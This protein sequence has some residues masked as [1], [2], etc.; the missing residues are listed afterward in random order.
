MNIEVID[1]I[2]REE[3]KANGYVIRQSKTTESIYIDLIRDDYIWTIRISGHKSSKC[4]NQWVWGK[5]T[6]ADSFR[7]YIRNRVKDFDSFILH[8]KI[9]GLVKG[10]NQ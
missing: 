8:Q 6:K 2:M 1:K 3:S 7:R 10:G 5:N 9:N 4:R